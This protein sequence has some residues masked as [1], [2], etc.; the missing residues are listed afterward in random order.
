M[1]ILSRIRRWIDMIFASRAKEEFNITAVTSDAMGRIVQECGRV[2]GGVPDWVDAEDHIKT[3]NF[4]KTICAETAA[5]TTLAVGIQ[6][7]GSPRADYLQGIIDS[8][9]YMLRH[10]TEYTCAYGTIILKPNGESLDLIMPEDYI[11]TALDGEKITGAVFKDKAA[12]QKKY[13]TRLEYHRFEDDGVYYITNRCFAGETPNDPGKAIAIEDTPWKGLKE[14]VGI[15]GLDRP[16]FGVF[17]TP[18]ANN[19][20]IGSGMGLPVFYNAL[21]ELKDLD[22]AYS[23]ISKEITDSKRTVLLDSDRLLPTGGRVTNTHGA[24]QAMRE[25][26]GLPD[27]VKNVYGDGQTSFYQEINPSLNTGERLTGLNALLSQIGFKC[28]FSDGYFVFDE[29]TGMITATQVESDDRRT[30]QSI[31]D[32]RDKL[33]SCIDDVVYAANAFADLYGLAPAGS[34]EITYDFGDIVYNR[35]DDKIRW[36]QY[37]IAGKVPAWYYFVKFEGFTED[38]AKA[39]TSDETL[40]GPRLF[41]NE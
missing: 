19:V 39:L 20:E 25:A 30:I 24:F 23:R 9:Y 11:V 41:E 6:I 26:M 40:K 7:D 18:G 1:S 3:I 10:W 16:L 17:R 14:E 35:E 37:V 4:A 28:G 34:Y 27:Y 8:V 36:W 15:Q 32:M 2:Y 29:K 22:V 21:E 5:L 38:E 12:D 33:E 31:K 13:Y